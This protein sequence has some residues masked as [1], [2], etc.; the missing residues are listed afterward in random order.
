MGHSSV[1]LFLTAVAMAVGR[2]M[3]ADCGLCAGGDTRVGCEL[4]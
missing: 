2:Q 1:A 4:L 3:G